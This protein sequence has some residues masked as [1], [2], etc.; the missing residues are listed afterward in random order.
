MKDFCTNVDKF[1]EENNIVFKNGN[2]ESF[3]KNDSINKNIDN[4]SESIHHDDKENDSNQ[5]IIERLSNKENNTKVK[6][7]L[8]EELINEEDD[9]NIVKLTI[10]DDR[11]NENKND[12]KND[13]KNVSSGSESVYDLLT[14]KACPKILLNDTVRSSNETLIE[15]DNEIYSKKSISS[16]N[17]KTLSIEEK[18]S[19]EKSNVSIT[20]KCK[21]HLLKQVKTFTQKESPLLKKCIKKLIN[22]TE[23]D[24]NNIKKRWNSW[25]NDSLSNPRSVFTE[26]FENSYKTRSPT[27]QNIGLNV[28]TS[29][30]SHY[31][32]VSGDIPK[33]DLC[34]IADLVKKS[35]EE[36][37]TYDHADLYKEFCEC[38]E[39][40]QSKQKYAII[41]DFLKNK[42]DDNKLVRSNDRIGENSNDKRALIEDIT[43]TS[44]NLSK[45]EDEKNLEKM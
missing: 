37:K 20:D 14:L 39:E 33:S 43:E 11:D 2:I 4:P 27:D 38:F 17:D 28:D 12:N 25:Y 31:R 29:I 19:L 35:D 34:A 8:S 6:E 22:D 3:W 16:E 40:L 26:A 36:R 23:H 41:P 21:E 44:T 5:E 24:D 18:N 1:V 42:K 10:D 45:L 7:I 30:R 13:N 9:R 32:D 15:D